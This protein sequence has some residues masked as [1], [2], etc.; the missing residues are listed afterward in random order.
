MN[1]LV[2]TFI[3]ANF[4]FE[5]IEV[6]ELPYAGA[7]LEVDDPWMPT[8]LG[9]GSNTMQIVRSCTIEV[10]DYLTEDHG[11]DDVVAEVRNCVE[12]LLI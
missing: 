7:T 3:K 9:R 6:W 1:V 2:W 11:C 4:L 8:Q 5:S 10:E 12:G